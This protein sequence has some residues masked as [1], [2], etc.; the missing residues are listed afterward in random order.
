[1]PNEPEA[2]S[3]VNPVPR[4]S[5]VFDLR[6]TFGVHVRHTVPLDG[7]H[8]MI[9][10]NADITLYHMPTGSRLWRIVCPSFNFAFHQQRQLLALA[11]GDPALSVLVWDLRTGQVHRQ[12]TRET[13]GSP[14]AVDL[15]GLA[16]SPDGNVLAAGMAG[17]I[18]LWETTTGRLLQTLP[19]PGPDIYTIAFHPN[20]NLLAA[21]S[22]NAWEVWIWA[23]D[24][25]SLL[26]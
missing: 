12:L 10:T 1:M 8:L 2:T 4:A 24:D 21:G 14:T 6:G 20:K 18:V 3:P 22:F 15:G 26:H 5:T 23:L 13:Q 16:F 17:E 25:N 11:P 19:T 9:H 7:D